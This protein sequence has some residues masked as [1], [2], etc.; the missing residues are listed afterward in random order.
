MPRVDSLCVAASAS[1]PRLRLESIAPMLFRLIARSGRK[2]VWPRL[3]EAPSDVDGLLRRRQ[4][5]LAAAEGG[6]AA[7]EISQ[8]TREFGEEG[9]GSRLRE[10][11]S[12][13]DGLLRRRQRLLAAAGRPGLVET[14]L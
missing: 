9:V 2:G 4:R 12:D 11:P 3:R 5:L 6:E 7:A 10:A 1:S 8:A 14:R 13:V